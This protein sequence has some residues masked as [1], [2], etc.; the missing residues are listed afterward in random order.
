NMVEKWRLVKS[1]ALE[2]LAVHASYEAIAKSVASGKAPNTLHICWPS[3]PYVCIGVHQIAE[4]D[5]D[6]NKCRELGIELVRRQVGGGTVYLDSD[7]FFYHII[8]NRKHAPI[9]IR[10]LFKRFLRPTVCTYRRFGLPAEY[11][12]INDVI[13]NNRKASGNGA[14]SFGNA[15]VIVG[16]IIA[17]FKPEVTASVLKIPDEKMRDKVVRSIGEWVT[18]L[19]RE[20]GRKPSMEEIEKVY[21]ECF[22][23]TFGIEFVEGELTSYEKDY[24]SMLMRKY[25]DNK[26]TFRCREKHREMLERLG[27]KQQVKIM[28]NH[29]II[30]LT[31][32]AEKLIRIIAEVRDGKILDI[33][34][35]GDFFLS[36]PELIDSLEMALINKSINELENFNA[37]NLLQ[38]LG[39]NVTSDDETLVSQILGII[40]QIK[41][42]DSAIMRGG[43]L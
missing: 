42:T 34:I 24:M 14:V 6:L 32:K 15:V 28:E 1:G 5:V 43:T 27:N 38:N 31:E 10:E 17:D 35:S 33:S 22:K 13:V 19:K 30:Q 12:P 11:R 36:R 23:E 20:L 21:I 29:Y 9:G 41:K 16:N 39:F 26:W 2:P 18:S 40:A 37:S 25:G 8:V 7:Q 4:L 3:R